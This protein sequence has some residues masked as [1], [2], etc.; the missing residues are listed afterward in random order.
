MHATCLALLEEI[1]QP[2]RLDC[3]E[4]RLA[5]RCLSVPLAATPEEG[6]Q[7]WARS[8]AATKRMFSGESRGT[9]V[10]TELNGSGT[11]EEECYDGPTIGFGGSAVAGSR[12]SLK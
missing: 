5:V 2:E 3:Q 11:G 4:V 8:S 6:S 1:N 12:K 10:R 9:T 7:S